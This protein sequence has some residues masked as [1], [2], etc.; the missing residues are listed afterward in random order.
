VKGTALKITSLAVVLIGL[1]VLGLFNLGLITIAG[2][3]TPRVR[4]Q[5]EEVITPTEALAWSFDDLEEA[6]LPPGAEV[7]SNTQFGGWGVRAEAGTP[8]E[9]NALCQTGMG[10]FPAIALGD[11]VL[12]DLVMTTRFKPIS[13]RVDQAAGLIFRVQDGGNYYIL[14]AN[15]LEGNVNLYRYASG[16][17]SLMKE[18]SAEVR[19]GDW[20]ELSVEVTGNQFRGLLNGV[21]VVEASDDSYPA[22][23]VG[24]WTK[25][26]SVTCFDD[27]A[28]TPQ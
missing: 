27:V 24:L 23:R 13:G 6:A 3:G 2:A 25:A 18:G 8:S 20:Q 17:R 28:A 15:A 11:A 4:Y 14:R 5:S 12:A 7:L 19:S 10:E 16:R 26:D 1:V 9:P 21:P 22:G